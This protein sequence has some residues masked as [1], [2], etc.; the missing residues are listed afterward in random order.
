MNVTPKRRDS[1]LSIPVPRALVAVSLGLCVASGARAQG[2]PPDIAGRLRAMAE[3]MSR[4]DRFS[5][6]VLLAR[7]GRPV[8]EQ[9]YGFADREARRRMM[10]GTIMNVSSVGKLFTQVAIGQLAAAGKLSPDST[11]ATYWPDY[12]DASVAR[13][14]TIRQLLTH[15]SGINGDIFVNL[16][17]MG[18]NRD[19]LPAATRGP[20]AFPPG[21]R[22]QYSNAGYVILG[23]IIERV[24]GEVYH[25]YIRRHVFAP[26]G[27][28]ASDFP[29]RDSLPKSA[30]IGYTRGEGDNGS[31][32]LTRAT[33]MQP[34][35][36]SAAGGAFASAGDLFRFV[37][38]RRQGRLGIAARVTSEQAA[39]G[40]PGSNVVISEGLPGGYDL[41]V[42]ANVDPMIAEAMADSVTAWLGGGQVAGPPAQGPGGGPGAGQRIIMRGPPDELDAPQGPMQPTL[43]DTPRG[44]AAAA[45]IRAFSSGDT[46]L[47][48]A[49]IESHVQKDERTTDERLRRYVEIFA[50]MGPLTILGVREGPDGSFAVSVRSQK[51]GDLTVGVLFVPGESARIAGVRF[52]VRR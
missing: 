37:M 41:I 9:A 33:D 2:V 48:R 8:L 44:R 24:S 52:E 36:G 17:A 30:A 7:G 51:N 12:P 21:T 15:R 34:M 1:R 6:V 50:D 10:P 42:L 3:T 28:T 18:R 16:S 43:P 45:Y 5:G 49:A 47:M 13:T 31:A 32:P 22:A 27:M 20:L 46:T 26:A 40:S 25:E 29:A 4:Q 38:A 11:I 23:E 39:G 35:R 19:Y 14:V